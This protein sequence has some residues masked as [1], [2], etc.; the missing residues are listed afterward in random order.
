MK[1]HEIVFS[2]QANENSD[3]A[4]SPLC[5][6]EAA[7]NLDLTTTQV[8]CLNWDDNRPVTVNT[9]KVLTVTL[10]EFL[11]P[12]EWIRNSIAWKFAWAQG[13]D[14]MWPEAWQR[15]LLEMNSFEQFICSKLLSTKSF[16]SDFRR[17]CR[18]RIVAWLETPAEDR[19]YKSPLSS[20]QLEALAG[21]NDRRTSDRRSENAYRNSRYRPDLGVQEM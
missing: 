7:K 19:Q 10:P 21:P 13:V 1:T 16:R 18:D 17:S 5:S 2:R 12:E 11:S 4:P 14:P 3:S 9:Y 8:C 15:G 6:V 20:R